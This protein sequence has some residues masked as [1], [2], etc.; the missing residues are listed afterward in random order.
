MAKGIDERNYCQNDAIFKFNKET[1]LATKNIGKDDCSKN[2][3]FTDAINKQII[4]CDTNQDIKNKGY[5]EINLLNENGDFLFYTTQLDKGANC[6]T[7]GM[8]FIQYAC[9]LDMPISQR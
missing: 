5:C 1:L 2:N 4:A 8:F 7:E 6:G 3:V 9:E